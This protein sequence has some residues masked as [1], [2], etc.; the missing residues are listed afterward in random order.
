MRRK[1]QKGQAIVEFAIVLPVILILLLGM[2]EW[3]FLM[4]TQTTFSNAVR[5]GAREAVVIND[6]SANYST[7]ENE[8]KN[9]VINRMASLPAAQKEDIAGRI[10]IVFAPSLANARS[11]KV[12]IS[13]QPYRSMVGFSRFGIPETLTVSSEFRYE[14]AN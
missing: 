9:I 13:N 11:I 14:R 1:K 8:V 12:A 10:T 3:G 6:W 5:E 2:L 4:W 7:R